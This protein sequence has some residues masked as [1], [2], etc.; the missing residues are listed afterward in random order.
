MGWGVSRQWGQDSPWTEALLGVRE[1]RHHLQHRDTGPR[2]G[3]PVTA[4]MTTPKVRTKDST[5]ESHAWP[6][7]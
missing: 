3:A 6:G 4:V 7:A 2:K 5:A 1:Q